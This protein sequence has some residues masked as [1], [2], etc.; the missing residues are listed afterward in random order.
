MSWYF[1]VLK[2]Y[3]VFSGRA[4]RAE[5]WWFI[6]FSSI[7][8]FALGFIDGILGTVDADGTVGLLGGI[9]SLGVLIPT[10]AVLVR[11]M[12]DTGHSGWWV[13][14]P[15]VNFVFAVTDSERETNQYGPDPKA[16]EA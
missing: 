3:S 8:S 16:A 9:Y 13:I 14:V 1:E 11:R 4:R 6:L 5:Y 15:I 12:H 7:I 10:I 2:K